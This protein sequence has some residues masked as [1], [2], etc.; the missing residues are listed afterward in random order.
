MLTAKRI[1]YL[2]TQEALG[3]FGCLGVWPNK[4]SFN[5]QHSNC[6]NSL[7]QCPIYAKMAWQGTRHFMTLLAE[8]KLLPHTD[9]TNGQKQDFQWHQTWFLC[10]FPMQKPPHE[11]AR[12]H[13]LLVRALIDLSLSETSFFLSTETSPRQWW[14]HSFYFPP[15]EVWTINHKSIKL[16]FVLVLLSKEWVSRRL[17]GEERG[18]FWPE[19]KEVTIEM[20]FVGWMQLYWWGGNTP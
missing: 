4:S 3:S 7:P 6:L 12:D 19:A 15:D 2:W 5:F 10:E 1:R 14:L 11:Q 17:T 16:R 20:K 18:E 9:L 13:S 8:W